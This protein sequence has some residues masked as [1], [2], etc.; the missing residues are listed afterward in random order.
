[1]CTGVGE[2]VGGMKIRDNQLRQKGSIWGC[3]RVKQ[4]IGDSLNGTGAIQTVW[5]MARHVPDRNASPSECRQPRRVGH[6]C[7]VLWVGGAITVASLS[8]HA[9]SGG[10]PKK[11]DPSESPLRAWC[12]EQWEG[13][14]PGMSF[15]HLLFWEGPAREPLWAPAARG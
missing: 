15:E 10:C 13:P 1:M 7:W 12:T 14:Q 9:G 8:P 4:L 5:T 11:E 2:A 3:R 6:S